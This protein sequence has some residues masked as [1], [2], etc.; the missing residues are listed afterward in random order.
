MKATWG[1][2]SDEESK[3]EDGEGNL[4]LMAKSDTESDSD[5]SEEL[6]KE[7]KKSFELQVTLNQ[8]NNDLALMKKWNK[9][10]KSLTWLN[11]YYNKARTGI[12]Y[13][14]K[15]VKWDRKRKYVGLTEYKL[16]RHCG[17][18]DHVRYECLAR[19]KALE[20]NENIVR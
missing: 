6:C 14:N 11:E 9:S 17:H 4:A 7:K 1:E 18:T 15:P 10:S 19:I 5:S 2:T 12:G 13:K 20:K 16:C 3:G 8:A